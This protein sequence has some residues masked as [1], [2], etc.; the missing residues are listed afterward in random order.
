MN[1]EP[2]YKRQ[3]YSNNLS[4][5]S[6]AEITELLAESK[7]MNLERMK[8]GLPLSV[9]IDEMVGNQEEFMANRLEAGSKNVISDIITPELSPL[10]NI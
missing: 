4:N 3:K 8:G 5:S 2:E 6:L 7:R 9:E 10:F 1:G